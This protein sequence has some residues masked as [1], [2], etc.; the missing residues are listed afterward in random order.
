MFFNRILNKTLGE[1]AK[2]GWPWLPSDIIPNT[3]RQ[4]NTKKFFF[5]L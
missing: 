2:T 3:F 1:L 5:Y 4:I